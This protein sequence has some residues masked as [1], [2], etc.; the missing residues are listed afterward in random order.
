M[1]PGVEKNTLQSDE[2]FY[3]KI[4]RLYQMN[5]QKHEELTNDSCCFKFS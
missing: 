2:K 5:K 3:N 4:I 1:D